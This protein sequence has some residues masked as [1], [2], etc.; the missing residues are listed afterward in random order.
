MHSSGASLSLLI[1]VLIESKVLK[2]LKDA[3]SSF[4]PY[5]SGVSSIARTG[6]DFVWEAAASRTPCL[7]DTLRVFRVLASP[8]TFQ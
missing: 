8:S 3:G 7:R 4:L 5:R 1:M 2:R 6:M